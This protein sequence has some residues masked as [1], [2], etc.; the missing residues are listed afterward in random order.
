MSE[1][2]TQLGA[3]R[4][5]EERVTVNLHYTSFY[6]RR[7]AEHLGGDNIWI[8]NPHPSSRRSGAV[9]A[10]EGDRFVVGLTGYLN[11]PMP[12]DYAG[13]IEFARSLRG[14]ELHELLRS[15]E[16]VSELR[17]MRFEASLRRRYERLRTA[18]R[19]LLVVG[20]ALC[21][22]NAIYG[23]GMTVAAREALVLDECLRAGTDDLF[24]RFQRAAAKLVDVPWSIVVGADYAFEGVEGKRTL[25][26]RA[27]NAFMDRLTRVAPDDA[28]LSRAFLSVM[29]LCAPP[30]SLF[31][32]SILRRVLMPK[33][34]SPAAAEAQA[35]ALPLRSDE[36]AE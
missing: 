11:E 16:P 17:T 33:A 31:A 24:R 10:V 6:I 18:P 20:D 4:A 23:Q 2:L 3:D 35:Q 14:P 27:M 30:S 36:A 8:D 22:F 19:G 26:V 5:A 7:A 15:T 1:W 29:H 28:E 21:C 34:P 13:A 32:P 25:A 9:L 12:S